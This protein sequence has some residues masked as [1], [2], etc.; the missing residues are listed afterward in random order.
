MNR[1]MDLRTQKVSRRNTE[2]TD[3]SQMKIYTEDQLQVMR[4]EMCRQ[5][6][7][8]KMDRQQV[9][10]DKDKKN[11]RSDCHC[12]GQRRSDL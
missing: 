4:T 6:D 8:R 10:I 2:G 7:Q 12:R 11:L 9:K 1:K 5:M 3:D